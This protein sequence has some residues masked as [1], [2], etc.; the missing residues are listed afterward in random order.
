M[1]GLGAFVFV[2]AMF[3]TPSELL[4]S[5]YA[6]HAHNDLLELRLETCL[7]GSLLCLFLYW[8]V[9]K[10]ARALSRSERGLLPINPS[11][12]SAALLIIALPHS[13]VDYPLRPGAVMAM[14]ALACA[15]LIDQAPLTH[16]KMSIARPTDAPRR[17]SRYVVSVSAR[18]RSLSFI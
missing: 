7:A 12:R 16:A 10:A 15:L 5:E 6:S 8:L 2:Y 17:R 14:T 11:L 1:A 3:E 4:P 13:L 9:G 18:Q